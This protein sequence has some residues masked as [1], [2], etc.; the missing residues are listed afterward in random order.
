MQTAEA[1]NI[2]HK[3]MTAY[4]TEKSS[5]KSLT[6]SWMRNGYFV[7]RS[8]ASGD[9]RAVKSFAAELRSVIA[10]ELPHYLYWLLNEYRP[11]QD[12][13][14]HENGLE[15]RFG[16]KAYQHPEIMDRLIANSREAELKDMIV[17]AMDN[18]EFS[19]SL[20]GLY[21]KISKGEHGDAFR[22]RY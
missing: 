6:P 12:L 18:Q 10:R 9:P 5:R 20:T 8:A 2:W 4:K 22:R 16:L 14:Q 19:C 15:Y 11:P 13:T 21:E 1:L 7:N 3:G 17:R